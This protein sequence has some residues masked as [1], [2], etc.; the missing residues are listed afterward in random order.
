VLELKESALSTIDYK[1]VGAYPI[2]NT[3]IDLCDCDSILNNINTSD[4]LGF[5]NYPWG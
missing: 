5:P 2:E 4:L 1:L 3:Y